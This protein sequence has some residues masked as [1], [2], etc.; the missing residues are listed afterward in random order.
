MQRSLG[1]WDGFERVCAHGCAIS[2]PVHKLGWEPEEVRAL[3]QPPG[4]TQVRKARAVK[5]ST[6]LTSHLDGRQQQLC[7]VEVGDVV[8]ARLQLQA[9]LGVP[10]GSGAGGAGGGDVRYREFASPTSPVESLSGKAHVGLNWR[11]STSDTALRGPHFAIPSSLVSAIRLP[12][13][14]LA[15]PR[16]HVRSFL[17]QRPTSNPTPKYPTPPPG[18]QWLTLKLAMN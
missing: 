10:A 2:P 14:A 9:V 18:W 1:A 16:S 15:I 17:T 8:D 5:L 4:A 6:S 3:L 13:S 7:E 12:P 11:G